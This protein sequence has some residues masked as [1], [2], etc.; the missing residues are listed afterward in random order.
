[1]EY[2]EAIIEF[3]QIDPESFK[4]DCFLTLCCDDI[5]KL[6]GDDIFE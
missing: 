1:M 2:L 6:S 5:Y 4:Y 3:L